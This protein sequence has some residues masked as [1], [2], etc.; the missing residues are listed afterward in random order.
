M[1]STTARHLLRERIKAQRQISFSIH[2][3]NAMPAKWSDFEFTRELIRFGERRDQIELLQADHEEHGQRL[4]E[5]FKA[6][7]LADPVDICMQRFTCVKKTIKTYSRHLEREEALMKSKIKSMKKKEE[8]NAADANYDGPHQ[9][10]IVVD[11][12]HH[13]SVGR[14]KEPIQ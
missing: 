14:L 3:L 9:C 4:I 13:M 12:F 1:H 5:H 10:H 11:E 6:N 8:E 7:S 2:P